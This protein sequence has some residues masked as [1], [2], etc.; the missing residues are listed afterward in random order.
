VNARYPLHGVDWRIR[1]FEDRDYERLP[2]INAAVDPRS[3]WTTESLRY[4]D[5]TREPRERQLR[6]VAE[7]QPDGVVGYGQVGHIWWAFHPRRY[8]LRI[9]VHPAWQ[10]RGIGAALFDRLLAELASWGA[11]LVRTEAPASRT[12]AIAFLDRRGFREWRRR[13]ESVLEVANANLDPLVKAHQR[14]PGQGIAITTY[15]DELARR[16]DRLAHDVYAADTLFGSD[17]PAAAGD[18]GSA[19]MSFERF[20]ATQLDSPDVLPSAHFLALDHGLIV[21]VSRLVREPKHADVLHQE[22]TGTHP[23]YRGRG[24]AQALKL[25]TI[26]FAREHGYREI[27]TSNDST[28]APMLHIN[29]AIGFQRQSPMIIFERRFEDA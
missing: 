3:S 11:A 10:H 12:T 23:A 20:A 1:A 16:G 5:A 25:R 28:N 24:I 19:M 29:D 17:E 27:R 22:L 26:Q 2:E 14:L 7:V 6:I 13:W 9:Q 18:E 21:G 8:L 4:R 15:A